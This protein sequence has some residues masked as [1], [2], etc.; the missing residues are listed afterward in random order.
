MP[1]L[2]VKNVQ[3]NFGG[4]KVLTEINFE[5]RSG[6]IL[7]LIGPNGAGKTSLF[8]ILT[9]FLQPTSGEIYYKG[10]K[11]I[12]NEPNKACLNGMARTFQV[13]KPLADLTVLENIMI[14][15]LLKYKKVR[16][17]QKKA[18]EIAKQ[19]NLEE[20][21]ETKAGSLP[22]G[23][24]KKLEIARAVATEPLLLL[25]DEPMGGLNSS[26]VEDMIEVIKQLRTSGITI[27]LVEHVMKALMELSDRVIVLH[28]GEIVANDIPEVIAKDPKVIA[29]YLGEALTV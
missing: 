23:L 11:L 9:G 24:R 8:N 20:Y 12:K 29:A 4:L 25:L 21:I 13:V 19:L 17:A 1:I 15:C 27:V 2:E 3:K 28:Q 5:V 7:G 16:I 18:V 22:I 26:E 10:T 14:G 6:E